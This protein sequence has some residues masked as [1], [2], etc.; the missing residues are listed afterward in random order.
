MASGATINQIATAINTDLA[1]DFQ[2]T[3]IAN[4]SYKYVDGT[5]TGGSF[6]N[7][8]DPV[9]AGSFSI[10]ATNGKELD[11][12]KANSTTFTYTSGATTGATFNATTNTV[13][14]TY[15]AGATVGQIASAITDINSANGGKIF[16]LKA[17]STL[18][19]T[20]IFDPTGA[21]KT[22]TTAGTNSSVDD[23]I[24]VTAKKTGTAFN[25]SIVFQQDNSIAAGAAQASIDSN[26]GNIIVKTKNSGDVTLS[27]ITNAIN[28]LADYSASITTNNGD[29]IYSVGTDTAPTIDP[30]TGGA[31]NG[32]L[33]DDLVFQVSGGSGSETFQFQKG[34]DIDSIIQSINLVKDATGVE[35][36][37]SSGNLVLAS[38]SYG[39]SNSISVKVLSE[40]ANGT[41]KTG[42]SAE[43]ASGTDIV[44]SVNGYTASGKG[45][46]LSINTATLDLSLTVKDGSST[47]ISFDIVGGGALFQLGS[48]VVSNQQARLGISAVST[49]KLGG[50]AG[51]LYELGSGQAKA[52]AKDATGAAAVV[53]EVIGKVTGIR[54]RLGAFQRTTLDS[55]T[56]SLSDS[57]SNL[58]DAQSAIR[59]ADF[60]AESAAL[61]RAQILVQSGTNVL[62]LA[63]QNP[64][65]VLSLLR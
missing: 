22:V 56:A 60:A 49:A 61:T 41:F 26:N 54:G 25:K 19:S 42:L 10:E 35:A 21:T 55:N 39:S 3:D 16:Q 59:D 65:N 7:G 32:G 40:G 18:N 52:L 58:T 57:I 47:N 36:S 51:R 30:L 6:A 62:S 9:A 63:N 37:K 24:T 17:G 33:A 11:G 12:T 44:A 8:T 31:A 5:V 20:A 13:A 34:A 48:D 28:G 43:R 4:G 45:N 29:G 1:S 27:A 64:Q 46:T 14:V 23:V 53:D 38:T 50:S 15:A 2:V